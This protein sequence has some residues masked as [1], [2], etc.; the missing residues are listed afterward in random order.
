MSSIGILFK[1]LNDNVIFDNYIQPKISIDDIIENVFLDIDLIK[2]LK[3][4]IDD[5]FIIK[6]KMKIVISKKL[7]NNKYID[8]S[9]IDK[10]KS[11]IKITITEIKPLPTGD[12][13]I[14]PLPTGDTIFEPHN[15][16]IFEPHNDTIFEPHNDTIFEPLND[17]IFEPHNDTIFEPLLTGDTI[18]EKMN[19][20]IL[21]YSC[22]QFSIEKYDYSLRLRTKDYIFCY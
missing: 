18:I 5:E 14:E 12:A 9:S 7:K 13:I 11:S 21:L 20:F 6:D 1:E 19:D 4:I 3:S 17:T 8:K 22:E 15:D 10:D 2:H 16:T